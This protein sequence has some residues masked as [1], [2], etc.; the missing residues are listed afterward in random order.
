MPNR[1]NIL[2]GT[3]PTR[4]GSVLLLQRSLK[5]KF[6]PGAWGLPCGK[7]DFGEDLVDAALREL[8]EESGLDGVVERMVG[9]SMFMSKKDGDDLHNV[10]VNFH[11]SCLDGS[12]V[13]DHSSEAHKWI[14]LS[15]VRSSGLDDFTIS[16]IEQAGIL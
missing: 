10:Q 9:Y 3:I 16:T 7:I 11:I 2:V 14:D 13:I 12:V 5:E 1:F 6:M 15:E 4:N 8:K